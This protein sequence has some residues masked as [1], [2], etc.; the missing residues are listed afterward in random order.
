MFCTYFQL[1]GFASASDSSDSIERSPLPAAISAE[2]ENVH[3]TPQFLFRKWHP[4][5]RR[6]SDRLSVK[7]QA[8][9]ETACAGSK[10]NKEHTVCKNEE[11]QTTS[12][13]VIVSPCTKSLPVT[14]MFI[15]NVEVETVL[16]TENQSKTHQT[17]YNPITPS[18]KPSDPAEK[19]VEKPPKNPSI[20]VP[21]KDGKIIEEKKK[22]KKKKSKK[23][24]KSHEKSESRER[25]K[26][27]NNKEA[28]K[29]KQSNKGTPEEKGAHT[30]KMQPSVS[31]KETAKKAMKP[32]AKR[33][34][35]NISPT[36]N[37]PSE[38]KAS[39]E[40]PEYIKKHLENIKSKTTTAAESDDSAVEN[41]Y[42]PSVP[43]QTK[44]VDY[45]RDPLCAYNMK[46]KQ[47]KASWLRRTYR[48]HKNATSLWMY[49]PGWVS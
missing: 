45:S 17:N 33:T 8:N 34:G 47:N 43:K 42:T 40:L 24:K 29:S 19:S 39:V 27:R 30:K 11:S 37:K 32:L 44:A 1:W 2:L 41:L 14:P 28:H 26:S 6:K 3:S 7:N 15:Q 9:N 5:A 36:F 16:E 31:T 20:E 18:I 49:K 38:T 46:G 4:V 13:P 22:K 10:E 35:T 23:S 12:K 21:A 48:P 25:S